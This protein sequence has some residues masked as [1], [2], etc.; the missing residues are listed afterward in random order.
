VP[1]TSSQTAA[2]IALQPDEGEALWFLGFLVTVKA[3]A[4]MTNGNVAVL[5]HLGV[6]GLGSPLH[7]HRN[8]D[9]WFYVT[10]GELTFWIGDDRITAPAGSFVYGPRGI[11][12]AFAVSSPQARF[13]IVTEPA[14]F[15]AFLRSL[16]VP[17]ATRTLPPAS[18]APPAM[19]V[20]LASAA[21]HGIEILGPPPAL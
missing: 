6:R 12:H 21:E 16:S 17:A 4:P 2:P 14:G 7:L 15:E 20:M 3:S 11:P 13:I 18:V 10:E 5:E 1:A 9:E 19:E 8:E